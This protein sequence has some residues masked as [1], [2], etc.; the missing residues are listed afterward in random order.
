MTTAM[1]TLNELVTQH[2]YLIADGAWGTELARR[3]MA[4]GE[5]P[6]T[7]NLSQP[8]AVQEIAGSY[9]AA[10]AQ[11][12][13]T[14]TFGGS[15][16]RPQ[17]TGLAEQA[18]E[19]NRLGAQL[20]RAAAGDKALVFGSIGPTGEFLRPLGLITEEEMQAAFAVQVRALAEG[21]HTP[22]AVDVAVCRAGP[23]RGGDHGTATYPPTPSPRGGGGTAD[24]GRK[25]AVLLGGASCPAVFSVVPCA[26]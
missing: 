13:L 19:L 25:R 22:C 5:T 15:P 16:L 26:V 3:G 2:D 20:S 18:A 4:V 23:R 7:R 1:P 11:I 21:G 10:G 12:I 24:R 17:R 6:E 9:V 14:N 8:Q